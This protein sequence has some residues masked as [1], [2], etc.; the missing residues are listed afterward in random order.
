LTPER[1]PPAHLFLSRRLRDLA[2]QL[3]ATLPRVRARA[4]DEAIHDMR[5]ALR[6]LRVLLRIARPVFGRFQCDA[7]RASFARVQR[8][9]GALRDEE[10]LRETLT[11]LE[12]H[13]PELDAWIARRARREDSLRGIVEHRLRA[14][15][16]RRPLRA[17][18]ALLVLPVPPKRRRPVAAFAHKASTRARKRVDSLLGPDPNDS[19]ALH[20]LRIAYK[21]LRYT[22]EIFAPALPPYVA[23]LAEPAAK[24]QKRL[25]E[26][27]DLDVAHVVIAR[28]RSLSAPAKARALRAIA[29]ARE[30]RVQRY[31]RDAAEVQPEG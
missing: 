9:S 8:A 26:I 5:V 27:H 14:G 19:A 23:A 29:A 22:T 11:A 31:L 21:R 1:L 4:D 24:F 12:L 3:A 15:D 6:R 13:D 17:L 2:T 20:Q 30:D 18:R 25:G 28:T 10:V 7:I 16:L